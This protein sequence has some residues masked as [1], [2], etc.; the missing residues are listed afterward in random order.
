VL[1]G[2]KHSFANPWLFSL[3]SVFYLTRTLT[4]SGIWAR[5]V[6]TAEIMMM[7]KGY[8]GAYTNVCPLRDWS[9]AIEEQVRGNQEQR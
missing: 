1:D 7:V 2:I 4:Q 5:R 8:E 6:D 9:F 3:L